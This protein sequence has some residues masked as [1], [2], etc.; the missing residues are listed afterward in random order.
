MTESKRMPQRFFD[1]LCRL[2]I[3]SQLSSRNGWKSGATPKLLGWFER[4]CLKVKKLA[5]VTLGKFLQQNTQTES[6]ILPF[7][8]S[9]FAGVIN[10]MGG[11]LEYRD[12]GTGATFAIHLPA[13]ES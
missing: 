7:Q 5:L 13:G 11:T 2:I 8:Y 9:G 4:I 3:V 6:S 1:P 10:R 12:G